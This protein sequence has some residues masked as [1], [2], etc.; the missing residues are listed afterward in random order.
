MKAKTF[1]KMDAE[2]QKKAIQ[3]NEKQVR[4]QICPSKNVVTKAFNTGQLKLL[5]STTKFATTQ[6]TV[7]REPVLS[8]Q[9]RME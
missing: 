6:M 4:V 8:A 1:S 9:R 3:S 2:V 5:A 7:N